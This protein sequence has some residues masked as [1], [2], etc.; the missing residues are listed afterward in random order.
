MAISTSITPDY[1]KGAPVSTATPVFTITIKVQSLNQATETPSS[2]HV[3]VYVVI[4]DGELTTIPNSKNLKIACNGITGTDKIS[5]NLKNSTRVLDCDLFG[6][7]PNGST[8]QIYY[9]GL[10]HENDKLKAF[11][12][13]ESNV[14]DFNDYNHFNYPQFKLGDGIEDEYKWLA[15][16]SFI[17]QGRFIKDEEGSA[18]VQYV[19]SILENP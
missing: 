13:G 7:T 14:A 8:I 5:V 6:R 3:L 18:Y 9:T 10:I 15:E 16:N 11:E 19:V 4:G 17:G 12:S 2:N 1:S